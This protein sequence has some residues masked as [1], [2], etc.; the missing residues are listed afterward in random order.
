M[1]GLCPPQIWYSYVHSPG[2][3]KKI[4]EIINNSALHCPM[5]LIF[6][7]LVHLVSPEAADWLLSSCDQ[8]QDGGRCPN[9]KRL[10]RYNSAADSLLDLPKF[11]R[12]VHNGLTEPAL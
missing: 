4:S 8:I 9:R 12:L 2:W 1:I 5:L 6:G 11:D 7:N 10:N 3:A